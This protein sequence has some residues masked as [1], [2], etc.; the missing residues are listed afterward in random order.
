MI[1]DSAAAEEAA[2]L[3]AAYA[4]CA[5]ARTAPKTRGIDHLHT[6]ILTGE[7]IFRLAAEMERLGPE[8]HYAFFARDAKCLRESQAVV[9]VGAAYAT[10]GLNEGCGYCG[11]RS[12][13]ECQLAG[14]ACVYEGIDLGIAVGSMVSMA[15]D[16]RV[17]NRVLFSAGR[18]ALEMGLLGRD[19]KC[20][21]AV[22]LCVKGKS[23]F[24]DRKA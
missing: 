6:L 14:A 21:L 13:A 8:L 9:L 22:P 17:D 18:A 10:R 16:L 12:C 1:Y 2:V 19:V 7:D 24:F 4:L 23:P 15:A 20:V 11:F 3:N 5:A